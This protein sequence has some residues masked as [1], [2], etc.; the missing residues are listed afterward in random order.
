MHVDGVVPNYE[1]YESPYVRACVSSNVVDYFVNSTSSEYYAISPSLRHTVAETDEK[2]KLQQ[3]DR[4]PIYLVIEE[5]NEL[6]PVEMTNGECNI[7]GEIVELDGKNVTMLIGGREGEEFIT[8][9]DTLDG[10]WPE[11]PNN[12]LLVNMILAG[13]RAGQQTPK[14]IRK[15]VDQ[16]CLVTDDGRFVAIMRPTAR[17]SVRVVAAKMMDTTAIRDRGSEI[18]A[19]IAAMEQNIGAPHMALL[20]N[21]MY[22]DEYKDDAYQRLQYLQLWQALQDSGRKYL[23][24]QGDS[25]EKDNVV[26]AGKKTL[27]ELKNYRDDIA[28]WWTDTI[29]ENFL[30]D[31]QRTI[32]E[33]IRRRYF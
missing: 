32:N 17:A 24:Y 3:K 27:L 10:A 23:N 7:L 11:L 4:T 26:V 25:I 2:I 15:Y 5:T 28:H 1:I 22:R 12:Q 20:V 31:L 30:A 21:A 6:T 19:A 18:K 14:P 13:V 9:W 16:Q 29:D 8:A 33:L